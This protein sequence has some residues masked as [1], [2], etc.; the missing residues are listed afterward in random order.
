[1]YNK[2]A[3]TKTEEG[4]RLSSIYIAQ[5]INLL[6]LN[7]AFDLIVDS[8]LIEST[9]LCST[10]PCKCSKFCTP[11]Q[12]QFCVGEMFESVPLHGVKQSK[13]EAEMSQ[14]DW[15]INLQSKLRQGDAAVS[16]VTSGDIDAVYIHMFVLCQLW[17]RNDDGTYKHP[18]YVILQKPRSRVDIYN[19][20]SMLE[21]FEKVYSDKYIGVKIAVALCIGGNDFIPKCYQIS[22]ETILK[23]ALKTEYRS[24]LLSINEGNII[25]NKDCFVDF[26]K[27]LYCPKRLKSYDLSFM[28]VRAATIGKAVDPTQQSGYKTNDP[29]RWLPPES[30]VWQLAELVQLQISYLQ[31]AGYHNAE[32]P[33]FLESSCLQKTAS[34]EIEYNFR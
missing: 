9:C 7:K 18:V 14:L 15:L 2:E 25:L 24:H 8:Q 23:M 31:T 12:R 5:H 32:M 27:N 28:D 11:L 13:G 22:H 19:V 21:H 33:K 26:F 4:K 1:M 29:R 6:T 20:T 34:G 16:L 3:I 30:A 10:K 17:E